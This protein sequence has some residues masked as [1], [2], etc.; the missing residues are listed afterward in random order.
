MSPMGLNLL[1]F[2][3]SMASEIM[4]MEPDA[5]AQDAMDIATDALI[6]FLR[7][8]AIEFGNQGYA[9]DKDAAQRIVHAYVTP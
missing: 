4:R 7:E 1:T 6:E 2:R 3:A 5:I 8:E 9:W